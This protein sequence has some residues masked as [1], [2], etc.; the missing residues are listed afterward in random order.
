MRY[1]GVDP[2]AIQC[3]LNLEE[4]KVVDCISELSYLVTTI[5]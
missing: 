3:E 1:P 2:E 4:E 5:L